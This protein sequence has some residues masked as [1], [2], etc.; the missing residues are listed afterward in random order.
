MS[1]TKISSSGHGT[2][3]SLTKINLDTVNGFYH[4]GV[5]TS[6]E[7]VNQF[8]ARAYERTPSLQTVEKR[9]NKGSITAAL[10][11]PQ[12]TVPSDAHL[13]LS[14]VLYQIT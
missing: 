5:F 9:S 3:D 2:G 1:Q 6:D 11:P 7:K 8:V 12:I 13:N 10:G 4:W 14:K